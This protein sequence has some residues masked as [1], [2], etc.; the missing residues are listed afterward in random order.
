MGVCL[1]CQGHSALIVGRVS[2]QANR[3][4][5]YFM[6]A[7]LSVSQSQATQSGLRTAVS[8]SF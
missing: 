6:V 2:M 5:Q 7:M 1:H 8:L 4:S 3:L